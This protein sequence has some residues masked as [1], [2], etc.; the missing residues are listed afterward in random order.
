MW[1]SI[2]LM[3]NS[4]TKPAM[5]IA[6][7]KKIAWFTSIAALAITANLPRKES[8]DAGAVDRR[9]HDEPFRRRLRQVPDNVFHHDDGGIDHQTEVDR[10]DR[11]QVRRLAAQA[12]A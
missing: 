1:P 4:G 6:A 3:V 8:T 12:A 9:R 11:Q 10:A 5:M 2:P 7:E